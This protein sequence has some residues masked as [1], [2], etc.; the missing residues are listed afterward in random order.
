M[1]TKMRATG[2]QLSAASEE[3]EEEE[4]SVDIDDNDGRHEETGPALTKLLILEK[5]I[6]S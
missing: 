6:Q 1:S 4:D 3:E 2:E 5:P